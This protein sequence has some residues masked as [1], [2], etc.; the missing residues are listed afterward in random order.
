[1]RTGGPTLWKPP[2]IWEF[3]GL[4]INASY[5]IIGAQHNVHPCCPFSSFSCTIIEGQTSCSTPKLSV[6]LI[7]SHEQFPSQILSP[8]FP[9]IFPYE[10]CDPRSRPCSAVSSPD[11][12]PLEKLLGLGMDCPVHGWLQVH[13]INK[14]Y[15]NP[16]ESS[17]S[18]IHHQLVSIKC[19]LISSCLKP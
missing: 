7:R 4:W 16:T 1:M 12:S 5:H 17:I 14:G 10:P 13:N 8:F 3:G 15:H 6:M 11:M 9:M 19:I 18:T 2:M